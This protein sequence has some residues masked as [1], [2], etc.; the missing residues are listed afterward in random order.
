LNLA[1]RPDPGMDAAEMTVD[2]VRIEG[3]HSD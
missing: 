1:V 2:Y 3:Q